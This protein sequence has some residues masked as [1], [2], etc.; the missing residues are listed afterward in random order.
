[1]SRR[2]VYL[3]MSYTRYGLSGEWRKHPVFP[4]LV[5]QFLQLPTKLRVLH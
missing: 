4:K 1:M 3:W 5:F 2:V